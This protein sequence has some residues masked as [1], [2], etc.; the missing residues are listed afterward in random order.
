MDDISS[1]SPCMQN[2]QICAKYCTK[3]FGGRAPPG[4]T[5]GACSS[6]PGPLARLRK[7]VGRGESGGKGEGRKGGKMERERKGKGREEEGK[8][9]AISFQI[10]W[11]RP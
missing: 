10:S 1:V 9:D 11:L 6:L 8:E 3:A 5:G 7:R 4:P 2:A